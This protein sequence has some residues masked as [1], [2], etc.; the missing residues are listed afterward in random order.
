MKNYQ[1]S[2]E[3]QEMAKYWNFND[4]E[5]H[6]GGYCRA[7][8][9]LAP[10]GVPIPHGDPAS[11]TPKLWAW[12]YEILA[13]RS[14]CDVGCGEG[15]AAGY[16]LERNC[17][18]IGVDGS[19]LAQQDSRIP[20]HHLLH[21]FTKGPFIPT[22]TFDLVWSCEFIEHV[23]ACYESHFLAT[24]SRSHKYVMFTYAEPGQAGWHHVNCQPEEYWIKRLADLG[25]LYD[26]DLTQ[27]SRHETEPGHFKDRGLVFV[28]KT[29]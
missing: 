26:L 15:H 18:V 7:S 14:M 29:P 28:K 23:E 12:I 4:Q 9:E 2:P 25:F 13:V 1:P 11:W 20:G 17:E 19:V 6:L 27:K 3:E 24:F 16:F 5:G 8:K 22:Q 10:I 21:D